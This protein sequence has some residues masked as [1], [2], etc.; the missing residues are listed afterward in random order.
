M[1]S[2]RRKTGNNARRNCHCH[3]HDMLD[4]FQLQPYGRL[5]GPWAAIR[6]SRLKVG[7][8]RAPMLSPANRV[9]FR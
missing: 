2:A 8:K 5:S 6:S 1:L 4:P 7:A 3:V 9:S